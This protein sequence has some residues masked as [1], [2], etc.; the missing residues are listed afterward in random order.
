VRYLLLS[1]YYR[2]QL[3]FTWASL[4]YAEEALRRL[5]DCLARVEAV[6]RDGAHP[7]VAARVEQARA[8]FAEAMLQDLN[9]AAALAAM[10]DL[11]RALNSAI[12]AGEFGRGDQQ[13]VREA[14]DG[15]DR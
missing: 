13:I 4:G 12:D 10:F 6:T 7:E 2:K 3:N 15:F 14:F 5:T 1:T 11:V 9:T 8:E